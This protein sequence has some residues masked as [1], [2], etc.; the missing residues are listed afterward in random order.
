MTE[1][2]EMVRGVSGSYQ[3]QAAS[4]TTSSAVLRAAAPDAGIAAAGNDEA[5]GSSTDASLSPQGTAVDIAASVKLAV[6]LPPAPTVQRTADNDAGGRS[7]RT[8]AAG[9]KLEDAYEK[10]EQ[11]RLLHAADEA[12]ARL[13]DTH[14]TWFGSDKQR[15]LEVQAR[16][17]T[18]TLSRV[19]N[20]RGMSK[21]AHVSYIRGRAL[22]VLTTF[23]PDAEKCLAKAVKLHPS[24]PDGWTALGHCYWKKPDLFAAKRCFLT[25]LEKARKAE[26]LRQLSM[27]LRQMPGTAEEKGA[28]L[29]ESLR[30]AKEAVTLEIGCG[31]SW[32]VLGNGYVASFFG[33]SR[34]IK[35]LDRALQAYKKAEAY[36][37]EKGNPDLFFNRAQVF[38]YREDYPES[39]RDFR[40]AREL[41]PM[42]PVNQALHSIETGVDRLSKLVEKK[43]GFK[44]KRLSQLIAPLRGESLRC[45]LGDTYRLVDLKELRL[46]RNMGVAV[47]L[48]V[49]MPAGQSSQPPERLVVVDRS[50]E[51]AVLSL[52]SVSTEACEKIQ[53]KDTL[54]VRNPDFRTICLS[55]RS[56]ASSPQIKRAGLSHDKPMNAIEAP[57]TAADTNGR[58][59][60]GMNGGG[61][62]CD[63]SVVADQS[64]HSTKS[65]ARAG[66][67]P[68]PP[69]DANETT[70]MNTGG[71]KKDGGIGTRPDSGQNRAATA[72][73]A[74]DDGQTR[75][76]G[77]GTERISSG[78]GAP[79]NAGAVALPTV[80]YPG[81]QAD[82]AQV[83]LN[84]ETMAASF[85]PPAVSLAAFDK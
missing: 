19:G 51:C 9:S 57:S 33:S 22:D 79:P 43:G 41:D 44:T 21:R 27:L 3:G 65:L 78:V 50:G 72:A 6:S 30:L 58:D 70:A 20:V 59:A 77:G 37:G 34:G 28:Q 13:Y 76:P 39:I 42:L 85:A 26:T 47:A 40:L 29:Q 68:L 73:A 1:K 67:A 32:Y 54:V 84:G 25:S 36:G 11:D 53:S 52:Y 66:A 62:T 8:E 4:S 45:G 2:T 7:K 82:P 24:E 14:D 61:S 15:R 48:K 17:V 18:E 71:V 55:T 38:Q 10:N 23:N 35:D 75:R 46:G 80:S 31:Y 5:V 83:L 63:D 81:I 56:P 64:A 12:L 60:T 16:E 74:S 69:R 49:V